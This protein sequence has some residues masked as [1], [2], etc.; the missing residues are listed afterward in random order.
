MMA[1][2]WFAAGY[3][4]GGITGLVVFAILVGGDE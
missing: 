4:L 2:A 1:A 3:I